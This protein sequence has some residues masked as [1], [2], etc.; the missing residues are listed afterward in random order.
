M[1]LALDK[2][3]RL[4][5]RRALPT[6]SRGLRSSPAL[7]GMGRGL[8]RDG[9]AVGS[10]LG[11]QRASQAETVRGRPERPRETQRPLELSSGSHV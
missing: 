3:A 4:L 9:E 7:G 8:G 1:P 10:R 6:S 2:H 5:L 11:S